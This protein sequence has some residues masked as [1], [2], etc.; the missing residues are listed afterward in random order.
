[1]CI[2]DRSILDGPIALHL[3]SCSLPGEKIIFMTKYDYYPE[4]L[5]IT[6]YYYIN[7]QHKKSSVK[8]D[9]PLL[10]DHDISS[11]SLPYLPVNITI[12]VRYVMICDTKY[13]INRP[14]CVMHY[15]IV[16]S[17]IYS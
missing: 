8:H 17:Y 13:L 11:T 7:I 2:R 4:F 5:C 10:V 9:G 1:M 6:K 15:E 12:F 14:T 3:P 16:R